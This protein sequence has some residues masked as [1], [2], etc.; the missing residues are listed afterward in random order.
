MVIIGPSKV[1]LSFMALLNLLFQNGGF[2]IWL[3]AET[4][5][6]IDERRKLGAQL[7]AAMGRRQGPCAGGS[8]RFV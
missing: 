6:R 8:F 1:P 4:S 7:T 5:L 2:K 3:S